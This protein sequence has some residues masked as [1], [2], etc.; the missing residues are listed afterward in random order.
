MRILGSL[1]AFLA[2]VRARGLMTVYRPL[3]ARHGRN[4]RFDPRGS[5]S[6]STITVGDDVYLGPGVVLMASNSAIRI[7]NKVMFGPGVVV[8]GGDHNTSPVGKFMR[9]VI[10][11]RP[12]DD[13]PVVI[14]DD[15]WVGSRAIVLKGVTIG[16]GAIIGAGAVVTRSVPPYAVV[17]GTPGRVVRFRWDV[18]TV[19]KHEVALYPAA[20]RMTRA[21]IAA[22]QG[23]AGAESTVGPLRSE[24]VR[25]RQGQT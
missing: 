9:D 2:R 7:G 20:E 15:V 23:A 11:K 22:A 6:F 13:S 4:F 12:E 25:G 14:E 19:L 1:V 24:C 17:V 21:A 10:Q 5:Y 3:F 8:I 18:D 16:R